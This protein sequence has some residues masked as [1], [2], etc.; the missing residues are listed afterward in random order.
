MVAISALV[1]RYEPGVQSVYDDTADVSRDRTTKWLLNLCSKPDQPENY[2][3]TLDVSQRTAYQPIIE[4]TEEPSNRDRK[5]SKREANESTSFCVKLSVF[6]L[7]AGIAWLV[8][9]LTTCFD[10]ISEGVWWAIFLICLSS[11]T[12]IVS[13]LA[14]QLQPRNSATFPFMVPGIPYV[15]AITIF[16]NAVLIANLHWMTY[17]R[18]GVWMT[19]GKFRDTILVDSS[20]IL[21][22]QLQCFFLLSVSNFIRQLITMYFYS[23]SICENLVL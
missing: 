4:T 3:S 9:V 17:L 7:V 14:I 16:I 23:I 15:S 21:F 20:I 2:E 22:F 13:L 8:I 5:D 19:L 11:G 6:C 18:F 12:I 1:S 10:R